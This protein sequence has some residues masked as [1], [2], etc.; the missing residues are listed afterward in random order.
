MTIPEHHLEV[1][2]LGV[3][4]LDIVTLVDHFPSQEQVQRALAVT[5][6]GGGPVATAMVTLARLGARVAMLDAL[7][8]DWCANL[9]REEFRHEGV[10]T[11]Y[12]KLAPGYTSS[13]ASVLVRQGDG[14]RSIVY[15]PG[16][17]PQLTPA[18]VPGELI[19]SARIMHLNGRH[20]EACLQACQRARASQTQVSF[21]GGAHR[22]RPELEELVPLT[23]ICIVARDFVE[24]YTRQTDVR[25]GA[26][27]LLKEGPSLVVITDGTRGSWV[28]PQQGQPFHQPAYRPPSVVDTTGCG[29]S[30]HGAFLFG[31]LRGLGLEQTAALASAVAALNSQHLGGRYGLPTLEQALSFISAQTA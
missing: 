2:G 5:V 26:E 20:W 1:V 21:D 8:D 18:D 12:L 29:D 22:Y 7:G 25:K 30:Y 19:S 17:A 3:S 27:M 9:I 6:Q 24:Q 28:H 14:A 11:D 4:T 31:L 15:A 16:T 13:I 23:D 10:C